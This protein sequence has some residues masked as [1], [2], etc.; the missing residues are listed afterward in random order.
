MVLKT[1]RSFDVMS[2]DAHLGR[3]DRF[4]DSKS[5]MDRQSINTTKRTFLF[6]LSN[7]LKYTPLMCRTIMYLYIRFSMSTSFYQCSPLVFTF[8]LHWSEGQAGE[9][10]EQSNAVHNSLD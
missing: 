7:T 6:Y 1:L 2:D 4:T 5:M 10:L 3:I 8:V 9:D